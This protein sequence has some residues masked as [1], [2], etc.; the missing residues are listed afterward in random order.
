MLVSFTR[1]SFRTRT[2]KKACFR[3]LCF[4]FSYILPVVAG[5][6]CQLELIKGNLEDDL[7]QGMPVKMFPQR[8]CTWLS[9]PIGKAHLESVHSFPVV[10]IHRGKEK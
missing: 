5:L 7:L 2:I 3:E 9:R 8:I 1:F 10:C 6:C 4:I